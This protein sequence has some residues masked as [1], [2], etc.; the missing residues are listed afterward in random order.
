MKVRC[1]ELGFQADWRVL[2]V[3][4]AE[5]LGGTRM[6]ARRCDWQR[7]GCM[8]WPRQSQAGLPTLR[9]GLIIAPL[10]AAIYEANSLPE[11]LCFE[12][13]CGTA[14]TRRRLP[15]TFVNDNPLPFAMLDG[16]GQGARPCP[17]SF[18]AAMRQQKQ[19]GQRSVVLHVR[20][21]LFTIKGIN[22]AVPRS[23]RATCH[24]SWC[25]SWVRNSGTYT[26][27]FM[28]HCRDSQHM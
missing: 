3:T 12:T 22:S 5:H 10:E 6:G 26:N 11:V 4:L 24:L 23:S 2:H 14:A 18:G 17:P 7:A 28:R 13:A 1:V 25:L 8:Q 20:C 27:A 21:L 15:R 16:S 19:N 9:W